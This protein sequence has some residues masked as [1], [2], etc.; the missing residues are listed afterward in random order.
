MKM[1]Q[2]YRRF[3]TIAWCTLLTLASASH[4]EI[5]S[6]L[7]VTDDL[8]MHGKI[9]VERPGVWKIVF[10]RAFN[11][12]PVQL[13]DV[14]NDPADNLASG[15][16]ESPSSCPTPYS[17]GVTFDYDVYRMEAG[18]PYPVEYMTTMG[19]NLTPGSGSLVLLENSEARVRI[20][21]SGKL[22][23]N[24]GKG[25]ANDP[26][27]EL[28]FLHFDTYWTLYPSGKIGIGF[29][30]RI[31]PDQITS[32][33]NETFSLHADGDPT[34]T[35]N[36]CTD[37]A[38]DTWAGG[39]DGD[40]EWTTALPPSP[41]CILYRQALTPAGNDRLLVHATRQSR[42]FG[43]LLSFFEAW[44]SATYGVFDDTHYWNLS[45]TQLGY[46][47][48]NRERA[49]APHNRHF[50]V[51]LGSE[52][53]PYLPTIK[54]EMDA[55]P[56]GLDY[57][58][59]FAQ[60]L[61][62]T[63]VP[64]GGDIATYGFN[65]ATGAYEITAACGM[66]SNREASVIFDTKG[67]MRND[68]PYF[69]PAILLHDFNVSD[70][71]VT[72][73]ISKNGG[74]TFPITLP[75][76]GY[77]FTAQGLGEG[78]LLFQLHDS[79]PKG[80]TGPTAWV[81]RLRD[82]VAGPCTPSVTPSATPTHTPS[83]TRSVPPSSTF[84]RTITATRTASQTA[85][86]TQLPTLSPTRTPTVTGTPIRTSTITVAATPT[87][88][89]TKS[90]TSTL[91]TTAAISQTPT[92]T[93][94]PIRADGVSG[95]IY[96]YSNGLGVDGVT[97]SLR[98]PIAGTLSVT[99]GTLGSGYYRYD[100]QLDATASC[101][102]SDPWHIE[103]KKDG[104][105]GSA[106]SALDAVYILQALAGQRTLTVEQQLAA[107][108]T[109]NGTVSALD[110]VLILQYKVGL[111]TRFPVATTCG[112]DWVFIPRPLTG[113]ASLPQAA[114]GQCSPGTIEVSPAAEG[115][116]DGE[117]F[118][119]IVFG[120]LTGNWQPATPTPPPLQAAASRPT[121]TPMG[122]ITN[123]PHVTDNLSRVR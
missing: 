49:P 25:L 9:T 94:T 47:D 20:H 42:K 53:S 116:A 56:Y 54:T 67:G 77:N 84:T 7:Q 99:T 48:Q 82:S 95:H 78:D 57:R 120:D 122:W 86:A 1:G 52:S 118:F 31:D 50:L 85:T 92:P 64:A 15:N 11:G 18:N 66:L 6:P 55:E 26:F 74:Q 103:P 21:Q 19:C 40:A 34:N 37:G 30:T 96:Y 93:Q 119:A 97:V 104:G 33:I 27:S 75:R 8:A 105:A 88:T 45:Y 43:M 12:G 13:Y 69:S 5:S 65:A 72:V 108:V 102:S 107:D 100:C 90:P 121:A 110:A 81:I 123:Y 59:P 24:D 41:S 22:R 60:A 10:D 71:N 114:A 115:P 32:I 106:I 117:D 29:A 16:A 68:T 2:G 91:T 44:P 28:S 23:R 89:P 3:P 58:N 113:T 14:A 76:S 83:V 17:Q 111:I 79:I 80:S 61:T 101:D 35:S 87:R 98:G 73:E 112:S 46:S 70:A 63:L 38:V 62:G 36:V 4:A 109:G 51:Q 39:S